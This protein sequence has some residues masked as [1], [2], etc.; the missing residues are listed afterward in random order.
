MI[1][2]TESKL[3]VKFLVIRY[4]ISQHEYVWPFNTVIKLEERQDGCIARSNKCI[5]VSVPLRTLESWVFMAQIIFNE[6]LANEDNVTKRITLIAEQTS[7]NF[8]FE[9]FE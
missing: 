8:W 4:Q 9:I 7:E 2:L 1:T 5:D 6:L 3:Y